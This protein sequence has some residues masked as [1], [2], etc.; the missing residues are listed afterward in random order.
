M[1][2]PYHLVWMVYH[3]TVWWLLMEEELVVNHTG[4]SAARYNNVGLRRKAGH[5]HCTRGDGTSKAPC[6]GIEPR[7]H[8]WDNPTLMDTEPFRRKVNTDGFA[9]ERKKEKP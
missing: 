4:I 3:H 9:T 5:L 6:M 7:R 2:H 1:I 8:Q